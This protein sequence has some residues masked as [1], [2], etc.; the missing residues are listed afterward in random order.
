MEI[1]VNCD[2]IVDVECIEKITGGNRTYQ[3]E[4][5]TSDGKSY[6]LDFPNVWDIRCMIENACFDRKFCH[7]EQFKSR[8]L[9]VQ[10]STYM[11]YFKR[12]ISGTYPTDGLKDYLIYDKVDTIVE[13]LAIEDPTLTEIVQK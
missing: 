4:F 5:K 11:E 13:V 8:I 7:Q 9:L 1:L 6:L 3:I 10:N 2:F 12:Q